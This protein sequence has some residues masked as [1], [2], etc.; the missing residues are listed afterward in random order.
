VLTFEADAIYAPQAAYTFD[1]SGAAYGKV[2]TAYLHAGA[3]EL[4]VPPAMVL[5]GGAYVAGK[6]HKYMF[7]GDGDNRIHYTIIPYVL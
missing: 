3:A 5:D 7:M 4:V 1:V 6:A 2:V